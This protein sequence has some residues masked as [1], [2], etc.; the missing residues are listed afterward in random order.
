MDNV[1]VIIRTKNEERWIGHTLQSIIDQLNKP[2][3]IVVENNSTDSTLEII[4]SFKQ[5][6]LLN[7]DSSSQYTDLKIIHID[8]YAPGKAINLGVQNCS[9]KYVLLISSHCVLVKINLDKHKKDLKKHYCVYGNQD[10][11]WRGKKITKRYIWDNFGDKEIVDYYSEYENRYFLHNA[12]AFYK[13]STLQEY[14]FDEYLMGKEDR[15]WA[16]M[17]IGN[18]NSILYD[19]SLS[20]LHHYTRNG[21]TWKGIG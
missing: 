3:I 13:K 6:P 20:A 17:I 14:P 11:V 16:N 2:E 10:P 15:Y 21:N 5:D 4:K 12:L 19:P 8:D 1:S 9:N 18:G 7:E